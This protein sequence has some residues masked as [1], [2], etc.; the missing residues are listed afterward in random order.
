MAR[1]NPNREVILEAINRIRPVLVENG[2]VQKRSLPSKGTTWRL[3]FR[4]RDEDRGFIRHRSMSL[5][6][7]P[8]FASHI[9][10]VI[11]RWREETRA[12]IRDEKATRR[13]EIDRRRNREQFA[14]ALSQTFPGSECHRL[15]VKRKI[16]ETMENEPEPNLLKLTFDIYHRGLVPRKRRGRPWRNRLW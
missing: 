11:E 9:E 6:R 16:Q 2:V 3:R 5:G 8:E 1:T 13:K 12:P 7:D 4:K 10:S 14:Q 15:R